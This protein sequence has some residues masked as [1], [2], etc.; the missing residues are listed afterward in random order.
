MNYTVGLYN[1]R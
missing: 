1:R